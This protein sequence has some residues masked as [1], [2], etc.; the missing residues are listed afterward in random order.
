MLRRKKNKEV[1]PPEF[2]AA[3]AA[4]KAKIEAIQKLSDPAEQLLQ[5]KALRKATTGTYDPTKVK[6]SRDV[7]VDKAL[8]TGTKIGIGVGISGFWGGFFTGVGFIIAGS[9]LTGGIAVIAG[10]AAAVGGIATGMIV[11]KQRGVAK[12]NKYTPAEKHA[13]QMDSLAHSIDRA[14]ERIVNDYTNS[15]YKETKLKA[16][17]NSPARDEVLKEFPRISSAFNKYAASKIEEPAEKAPF[18]RQFSSPSVI[19]P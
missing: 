16:L 10:A 11:G 18:V 4:L 15:D 19:A 13:T 1:V 9:A 5:Y 6:E 8:G 12:F 3:E 14:L 7:V 17:E 2:V